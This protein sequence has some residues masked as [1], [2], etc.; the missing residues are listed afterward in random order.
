MKAFKLTTAQK[1][2]VA[3]S[4][5]LV[6]INMEELEK[7][8]NMGTGFKTINAS[9]TE[10]VWQFIGNSVTESATRKNADGTPY[11]SH[12]MSFIDHNTGETLRFFA[13]TIN[14]S[15]KT[16]DGKHFG[17]FLKDEATIKDHS[18]IRLIDPKMQLTQDDLPKLDVK[19][20]EPVVRK[21]LLR[22]K[23]K[24]DKTEFYVKLTDAGLEYKN[25]L[26][27]E[28]LNE[29]GS[30]NEAKLVEDRMVDITFTIQFCK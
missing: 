21:E 15:L 19:A 6:S 24:E 1:K 11:K 7:S 29:D 9:M 26:R 20:F 23:R 30:M 27:K 28:Y 8:R 5:S 3:D 17:S 18:V 10:H 16:A 4:Q 2:A 25:T 14:Q 22:L 13:S 12:F